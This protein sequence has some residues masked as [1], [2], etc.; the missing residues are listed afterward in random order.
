MAADV[1]KWGGSLGFIVDENFYADIII[2]SDNQNLM[3]DL[4]KRKE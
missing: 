4:Y 3:I 1:E 2:V